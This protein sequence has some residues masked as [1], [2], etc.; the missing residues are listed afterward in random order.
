MIEGAK[1]KVDEN[2]IQHTEL[3]FHGII[4]TLRQ[5]MVRKRSKFQNLYKLAKFLVTNFRSNPE[6]ESVFSRVYKTFYLSQGEF[7]NRLDFI[8]ISFSTE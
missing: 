3:M 4:C 1:I 6:E 5:Y 8:Q 2:G 7:A